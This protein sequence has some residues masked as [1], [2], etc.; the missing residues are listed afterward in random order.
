MVL[1]R[2][3]LLSRCKQSESQVCNSTYTNTISDIDAIGHRNI[4]PLLHESGTNSAAARWG[5]VEG[6]V[7]ACDSINLH[8]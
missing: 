6:F 8:R 2:K 7:Q 5:Q 3:C 1:L 4:L